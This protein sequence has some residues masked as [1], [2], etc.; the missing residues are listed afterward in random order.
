MKW[1]SRGLAVFST[2]LAGI[3]A[4]SLMAVW[5]GLYLWQCYLVLIQPG[6]PLVVKYDS[7]NGKRIFRAESFIVDPF[8]MKLDLIRPGL[9]A[10]DGTFFVKAERFS[11]HL[12]G[13]S[14]RV[15]SRA[16]EVNLKRDSMGLFNVVDFLP[17]AVPG[18]YGPPFEFVADRIKV[19]YQDLTSKPL[20]RS[21]MLLGTVVRQSGGDTVATGQ[22]A[23]S[24][25]DLAPFTVQL[26]LNGEYW[27]NLSRLHGNARE[28]VPIGLNYIDRVQAKE[29]ANFA[30]SDL[31]VDGSVQI[32]SDGK[33]AP[34]VRGRFLVSSPHV[35][36]ANGKVR[37]RLEG[38]VSGSML[39]SKMEFSIVDGPRNLSFDGNGSLIGTPKISG[40]F[41]LKSPD[42]SWPLLAEFVPKGLSFQKGEVQGWL[43]LA[44]GQFGIQGKGNLGSFKLQGERL[45]RV[46]GRFA[47]DGKTL[48]VSVDQSKWRGGGLKGAF[49][50]DLKRGTLTGIAKVSDRS[51]APLFAQTGSGAIQGVGSAV[52]VFSGDFQH[53]KA[54][55]FASGNAS[56]RGVGDKLVQA[57]P[58]EARVNVDGTRARLDRLTVSGPNGV[59]VASGF[60]DLKSR[61]IRGQFV[62]G[63]LPVNLLNPEAD[64][65]VFAKGQAFGTFEKP[66]FSAHV[67]GYGVQF[68]EKGAALLVAEI[69]GS[70]KVLKVE[71]LRANSGTGLFV[72][73]GGMNF[74]SK[75]IN[76]KFSGVNLSLSDWLGPE[77]LGTAKI[78]EG[79]V[80]G[81]YENPNISAKVSGEKIFA[82][83]SALD[84]VE[85]LVETNTKVLSVRDGIVRIGA[86]TIVGSGNFDLVAQTGVLN[87]IAEALPLDRL[88]RAGPELALVGLASGKLDA[89]LSP[90]GWDGSGTI[91]LSGINLNDTP[92]GGGS[93]EL[94]F[95]DGT[96]QAKGD[97][98]SL[99]RY[100]S[101]NSLSY[102]FEDS[103]ISAEIAA[104]NMN[105]KDVLTAT[106]PIWSLNLN[107]VPELVSSIDGSFSG[108]ASIQSDK[109]SWSIGN[110]EL[111]LDE[112]S[113][114]G[115]KAGKLTA[116]V[117]RQGSSWTV[118]S[119]D[120]KSGS[121]S[122]IASGSYDENGQIDAQ[123]TLSDF[124]LSWINAIWPKSPLIAGNASVTV[125]A[126]GDKSDPA[127]R[128]TIF[129]DQATILG[130]SGQ[131][132]SDPIHLFIDNFTFGDK[133]ADLSGQATFQGFTG[134]ISANVPYSS[135]QTDTRTARRDPLRATISFL[136]R[137]IQ[138]F[139]DQLPDVDMERSDGKVQLAATM[140]GFIEDLKVS[141][142]A[143]FD[144]KRFVAKNLDTVLLNTSFAY[145]QDNRKASIKAK[146]ESGKGG[147]FDFDMT[148]NLADVF[149]S[150]FS[151]DALLDESTVN[152]TL[153]FDQFAWAQ[154]LTG[155]T[156]P[157]LARADG[158]FK[159]GGQ[160][161]SPVISGGITLD[162]VL[163]N[164]P[165]E[166]VSSVAG[167]FTIDP[168][169]NNVRI[170]VAKG[171][172]IETGVGALSVSG[173]G[174]LN[175]RLSEPNIR[176]P[177]TL[178]AGNFRLPSGRIALEPGGDIVFS[179]SSI[180]G[181][182]PVARVNLDL[183][184]HTNV[185]SKRSSGQYESYRVTINI[186]GNALDEKSLNLTASSDPA[187]LSQEEILALIGQRD[188]IQGI[189]QGAF[190]DAFYSIA[191]PNFSQNLT[192]GLAQGLKLD[193]LSVD[194]NPFDQF[195]LS[196][197]KTV[198]K[199]LVLQA[200]R[201][202]QQTSSEA[203]KWE[204]K[205]VYRLPVADR[206]FS[207][208][209][210]AFGLDQSVPYKLTINWSK[211]F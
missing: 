37:G 185:V 146:G 40:N 128:A 112:L 98:G 38:S 125:V 183:E 65:S 134:A 3:A 46:V 132:P 152:G 19:N 48:N 49:E 71:T 161:R 62:A 127:G 198:G 178:D 9:K 85:M 55:I 31:E 87:A 124:E 11:I 105:I 43:T 47:Y 131:K 97:I 101:L 17:K 140:T 78:D 108:T 139:K 13:D 204:V 199:G 123:A 130:A 10:A 63:G 6:V 92:I 22:I 82:Y 136:E 176:V 25:M 189:A 149:G 67:E 174:L 104:F 154:K 159:I 70:S 138:D 53:P 200:T 20:N 167:A 95:L 211:R 110:S 119:L 129:V 109:D 160:L 96:V 118:P 184:G 171:S 194:Y 61:S 135:L 41:K 165:N 26:G 74:T 170:S 89:R 141:A 126:K 99:D 52:A 120:W 27:V 207:R 83:G 202:L 59:L 173:V 5:G 142:S 186:R 68:K 64:G 42:R 145:V 175:G 81:T 181:G 114:L 4:T 133:R 91:S 50:T 33:R 210:L 16:L 163:L 79:Q 180:G 158:T 7:A 193:Y 93:L 179:Y 90:R 30:A 121:T 151:L 156:L 76:G 12:S 23:V 77:F 122:L 8:H 137:P 187:D 58:F 45:D 188:L 80:S 88:V 144:S 209:R 21:A 196:A 60:A 162:Q 102:K 106:K 155:A 69:S 205:L 57:G 14:F 1:I 86:G 36:L 100:L 75:V 54:D 103:V 115:R 148:G 66:L 29:W 147:L 107:E 28:L 166:I 177:L 172:K 34:D 51:L 195:V 150:D 2:G 191:I 153:K 182:E 18:K 190:R 208:I 203:L 15:V 201:Q 72:A 116:K 169:M 157:T 44:D 32:A 56:V 117:S 94:S 197:G 35:A 164:L 84:G 168:Q 73:S 206:F 24:Q 113:F 111:I 39:L 143:Q 192:Q